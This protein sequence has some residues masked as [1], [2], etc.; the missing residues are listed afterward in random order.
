MVFLTGQSRV[1]REGNPLEQIHIYSRKSREGLEKY[2]QTTSTARGDDLSA[3]TLV[4]S[5]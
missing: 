2:T 3:S 1:L 5:T 4:T